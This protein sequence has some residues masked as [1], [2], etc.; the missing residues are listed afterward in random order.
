MTP[1]DDLAAGVAPPRARQAGNP[2]ACRCEMCCPENPGRTYTEAYRHLCEVRYLAGLPSNERRREY[3]EGPKGVLE[4]RGVTAYYR[5]RSDT[6]NFMRGGEDA[7]VTEEP[8]V[9]QEAAQ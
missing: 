7:L 2:H 6:W 3:L 1:Q 4:R 5:L 9:L 8:D